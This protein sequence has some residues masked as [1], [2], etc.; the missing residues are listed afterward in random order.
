MSRGEVVVFYGN[1]ASVLQIVPFPI[2]VYTA[3][4][5]TR[6]NIDFWWHLVELDCRDSRGFNPRRLSENRYVYGLVYT[7]ISLEE[8]GDVLQSQG[9]GRYPVCL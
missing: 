6:I 2:T 5:H 4:L 7:S 9:I 1:Y 8:L 3:T